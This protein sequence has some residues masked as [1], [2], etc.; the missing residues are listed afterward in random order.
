MEAKP[1]CKQPL[2]MQKAARLSGLFV[3]LKASGELA[4]VRRAPLHKGSQ[5]FDS[6]WRAQ[7][8]AE[9]GALLLD[10]PTQLLAI[11]CA[12]QAFAVRHGSRCQLLEAQGHFTGLGQGCRA[13]IH[14]LIGDAPGCSLL[15]GKT[16]PK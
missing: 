1:W 15:T 7:T 11:R 2:A 10:N 3:C 12:H 8:L 16:L 6:F 14:R 13:A 4:E 9:Q 5:R